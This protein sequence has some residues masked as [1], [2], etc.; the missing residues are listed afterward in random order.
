MKK[1]I[2]QSIGS[3]CLLCADSSSWGQ[4][5][6]WLWRVHRKW[7][8]TAG[9]CI[10]QSEVQTRVRVTR[11]LSAADLRLLA[12]LSNR[13]GEASGEK[14]NSTRLLERPVMLCGGS[15]V[16]ISTLMWVCYQWKNS[17]CWAVLTVVVF[18]WL[19]MV[20]KTFCSRRPA[21]PL[22]GKTFKR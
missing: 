2:K 18:S 10:V 7:Q 15:H 19:A 20:D 14:T 16:S 8:I 17:I 6:D 3:S 22:T 9:V 4:S 11:G 12:G 5:W 1:W 13:L 21:A